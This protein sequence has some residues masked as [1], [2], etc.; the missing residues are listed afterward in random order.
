MASASIVD[1]VEE[2]SCSVLSKEQIVNGRFKKIFSGV[3]RFPIEPVDIVPSEDNVPVQKPAR[4]VPVAIKEN[5][6][7]ELRAMAK[8]GII[9]KLDRNTLT[10]WLNS[11]VIVKKAKL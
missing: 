2:Q 5:F 9:S 4:R 11:Y 6:K 7:T 1:A 3:G 10:P 8:M